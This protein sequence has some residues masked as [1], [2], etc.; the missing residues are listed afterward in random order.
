MTKLEHA[1][2][3]DAL[4][5]DLIEFQK[6]LLPKSDIGNV[7]I[8]DVLFKLEANKDIPLIQLP[9]F[10]GDAFSYT[11][12]IDQFKTHIHNKAHL[13]DDT[14]IIQLQ[15]HVKGEAQIAI[16]G[17]GSK[18]IMY[19]T[20]LKSL[21]EQFGQS[22]VIARAVVNKLKMGEKIGRNNPEALKAFSLDIINCHSIM[23]RLNYYADVNANDSLRRIVMRLPDHLVDKWKGVVA[24]IRGRGQIPTLKH[25][26]DFVQKCVKCC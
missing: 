19:A 20:V 24:D 14:Q 21:K 5:D 25:I 2:S 10:D 17:L 13:K 9:S 7:T 15:M 11:D 1:R 26:D 3:F 23:H 6:T 4:I 22:S 8:A 12:F 16:S 18:G